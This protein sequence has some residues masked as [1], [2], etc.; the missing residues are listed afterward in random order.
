LVNGTGYYLG[1]DDGIVHHF[2][3]N[4]VQNG[5]TYYYALVAYDYGAPQI[6]P[7]IAP[8]EN[9]VVVEKDPET[10]EVIGFGKNVAV[11]VPRTTAPGYVPPRV[12][13]DN[14]GLTLGSGTITPSILAEASLKTGHDYKVKFLVDTL[15][16]VPDYA[17]GM[18]YLNNGVSVYD[19]TLDNQL[20]YQESPDHFS[21]RNLVYKDTLGYWIFN[22]SGPIETDIFDGLNLT[23]AGIPNAP[24][25][26]YQKSGWLTGTANMRITL[27][28]V[29]TNY[30]PWDYDIV[31]TDNPTAYT[32]RVTTKTMKNELNV[33]IDR[34]QLL[35]T[36]PFSFYVV[37]KSFVDK[38]GNY[39][40]LDLV[41]QDID[42]DLKFDI[43]KDRILV[44]P[45][46]TKGWWAGTAFI[47]DFQN[48]SDVS[49]LPKAND[50][51]RMTFNRPFTTTD[52]LTFKVLP[53]GDVNKEEITYSMS[54]IKVVPNPYVA[55]NAMEPSVSN[56]QLNQRRRLMFTHLPAQ[57]SIKIF[58]M[59]GVLVD[60]LEVENASDNGMT[61]WNLN[62]HEGLEIAAGVY[63]FHVKAKATG[64]EFMGKF[65]VVK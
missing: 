42:K 9:E 39:E 41:V 20:V 26:N 46:T 62:T 11:V 2:T 14:S 35:V 8:S 48:V 1:K 65:A 16:K 37:N 64:D 29:E 27:T 57:C 5:R 33:R 44:G 58:T 18:S 59:S 23:L 24:A 54:D 17:R 28:S 30:F 45:V 21:G 50:V 52:S 6:G 31:F 12:T 3:D 43:L 60:E 40:L 13:V 61:Q 56:W 22:Q 19:M 25:Y 4:T 10:E 38:D 53:P 32:G 15:Y 55:T 36:Q 49:G 63:I 51:Y 47:I 7:G 34:A